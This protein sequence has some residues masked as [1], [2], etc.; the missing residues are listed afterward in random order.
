MTR[1]PKI[2][3]DRR[4]TTNGKTSHIHLDNST[5]LGL[6]PP[7][8][9]QGQ[10]L[11]KLTD[12]DYDVY[13]EDVNT[14]INSIIN[15]INIDN[16]LFVMTNGDDS[17]AVVGHLHQP[18]ETIEAAVNAGSIGQTVV[19]WPGEYTINY[20]LN[21]RLV[22]NDVDL[23]LMP[24]TVVTVI[25]TNPS[26]NVLQGPGR[27]L[28][29][30]DLKIIGN[31]GNNICNV[32]IG[33]NNI[34]CRSLLLNNVRLQTKECQSIIIDEQLSTFIGSYIHVLKN[35][36]PNSNKTLIIDVK[37][38]IHRPAKALASKPSYFLYF[39]TLNNT[40]FN[41]STVLFKIGNL[42]MEAADSFFGG[43]H[44]SSEAL[45]YTITGTID[46][47][48]NK[49]TNQFYTHAMITCEESNARVNITIN[50]A[51]IPNLIYK[52][53]DTD[54]EIQGNIKI[55]ANLLPNG[56][57]TSIAP[58]TIVLL[59]KKMNVRFDLNINNYNSNQP[60]VINNLNGKQ[61]VITGR[62][63]NHFGYSLNRGVIEIGMYD[64]I[65]A[66]DDG[67]MFDNFT[68]IAETQPSIKN[69]T[70]LYSGNILVYN[71]KATTGTS[72]T[73]NYLIQPS[74]TINSIII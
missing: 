68:I 18:W 66:N 7:G 40:S 52:N 3:L 19:V 16:T 67:A 33:L 9:N 39:D 43:V 55:N 21:E 57:Q 38:W 2:F 42:D 6:L 61:T 32:P 11:T 29:Q 22:A 74:I 27:I 36:S 35:T 13:W 65:I 54:C 28:G 64:N 23:Y 44:I 56:S 1:P 37:N 70:T 48:V 15:P 51:N 41:T 24:G 46:N 5:R 71:V 60:V 26:C 10:V 8:G 73:I 31:T 4:F 72:G 17:T 53:L 25:S 69:N 45:Y 14:L 59:A 12:A 58:S 47:Y 34:K 49:K 63:K 30:G 62:V 20:T 50:N